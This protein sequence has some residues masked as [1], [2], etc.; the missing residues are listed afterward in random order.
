M[1]FKKKCAIGILSGIIAGFSST[2]FLFSLQKITETR[3]KNSAFIFLLPLAGFIIGCIYHY[4]GKDI[5]NGNSVIFT[6]A[7]TGSKEIPWRLAPIVFLGTLIT[8]L[9]GGS[10]GREGT[11]IQ[12]SAGLSENLLKKRLA[13]SSIEKIS[14]LR[15]AIGAGFGSSIGAPIAGFFFSIELFRPQKRNAYTECLLACFISFY[16]TLVLHAPHTYF[17]QLMPKW[18]GFKF[19]LALFFIGFLSALILRFYFWSTKN[20]DKLFAAYMNGL[21][22]RTTFGGLLLLLAYII[23]GTRFLGLGI[24]VIQESFLIP[25]NLL[26]PILKCFFTIITLSTGFRGGEFIPLIFMGTTLGSSFSPFL[27]NGLP[28]LPAATFAALFAGATKM[29]ITSIIL[30]ME[31]FGPGMGIYAAIVCTVC[32]IF[33]GKNNIYY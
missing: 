5:A 20:L 14:L 23:F 30:T 25:A 26:D 10:A 27:E 8:H 18:L 1:Q 15:A 6:A 4:L 24:P 22:L 11:A 29:P 3:E 9:T 33:S 21:P 12:M 32:T 19:I 17:P 31:L 16:I 7:R 28:Y 13:L 2:V